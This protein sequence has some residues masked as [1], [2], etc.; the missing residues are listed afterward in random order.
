MNENKFDL[1]DFLKK[2]DELGLLDKLWEKFEAFEGGQA[3]PLFK[4]IGNLTAFGIITPEAGR[5]MKFKYIARKM[6][7]LF[8]NKGPENEDILEDKGDKKLN[9]DE[10][11]KSREPLRAYLD[12]LNFDGD[13]ESLDKIFRLV[14]DLERLALAREDA[15][16]EQQKALGDINDQ[17]KSKLQTPSATAAPGVL[18]DEHVFSRAEISNMSDADFAQNEEVIMQQLAKGLIK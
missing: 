13:K 16:K 2:S 6:R 17:A 9:K 1:E 15:R 8:G 12:E 18:A 4:Y 11:L 14:L 7:N 3:S 5:I 10:F